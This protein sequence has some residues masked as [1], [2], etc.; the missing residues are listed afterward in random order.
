MTKYEVYNMLT[1]S[2]INNGINLL[3]SLK[4]NKN[5]I[6]LT[7]ILVKFINRDIPFKIS[8]GFHGS[9]FNDKNNFKKMILIIDLNDKDRI[10]EILDT[11][12]D[13]IDYSY[14]NKNISIE[15]K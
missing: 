14:E 5:G 10:N 8:Y 11:F 3:E 12:K 15:L 13:Y 7:A 4:Y 1:T 2:E 6:K 9:L